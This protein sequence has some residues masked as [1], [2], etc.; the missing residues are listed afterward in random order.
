MNI[1]RL[2]GVS[3]LISSAT[4]SPSST[5]ITAGSLQRASS[6]GWASPTPTYAKASTSLAFAV[7]GSQHRPSCKY[8][9]TTVRQLFLLSSSTP[10]RLTSVNAEVDEEDD[11]RLTPDAEVAYEV[12]LAASAAHAMADAAMKESKQSMA[13]SLERE[14][15]MQWIQNHEDEVSVADK[16]EKSKLA[17]KNQRALLEARFAMENKTRQSKAEQNQRALLEARFEMENKAKVQSQTKVEEEKAE[18]QMDWMESEARAATMGGHEMLSINVASAAASA[19]LAAAHAFA[20]VEEEEE[21]TVPVGAA[22]M[23]AE[24]AERMILGEDI[25]FE[26]AAEKEEYDTALV[27]IVEPEE[28]TVLRKHVQQIA[29]EETKNKLLKKNGN[30]EDNTAGIASSEAEGEK[31]T[32]EF[33]KGDN[34]IKRALENGVLRRVKH[35]RRLLAAALILVLSRRLVLLFAGNASR[36]L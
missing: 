28:L 20:E 1:Y 26:Q 6:F 16:V 2:I 18:E 23:L 10:T 36:L 21:S 35:K 32:T 29:I 5:S 30:D 27:P 12:A 3:Q 25:A 17:E 9:S 15:E 34:A 8:Q 19:S 24:T 11:V 33:N 13:A 14:K 22:S 31:Q 7:R 4:A